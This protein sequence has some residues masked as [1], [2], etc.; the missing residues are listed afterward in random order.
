[1]KFIVIAA[2][3]LFTGTF[4]SCSSQQAGEYSS[5]SASR[6]NRIDIPLET[7]WQNSITTLNSRWEIKANDTVNKTLVVRT[8]YHD[9]SV[10]FTAL[11]PN[12]CEF[13][14]SSKT[15][16]LLPNKAAVQSIYIELN[17]ALKEL[18]N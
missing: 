6:F 5:L 13:S 9:V 12:T 14:V 10:E 7:A 4:T 1:M 15:C 17:R 16:Y 2:A 8:F 11:T 18:E 3:I